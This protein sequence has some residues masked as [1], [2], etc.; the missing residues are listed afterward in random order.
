MSIQIILHQTDVLSM[1]LGL[2][3]RPVRSHVTGTPAGW[4]VQRQSLFQLSQVS[5]LLYTSCRDEQAE[6]PPSFWNQWKDG[7]EGALS[8]LVV[9]RDTFCLFVALLQLVCQRKCFVKFLAIYV[10][11]CNECGKGVQVG[12][13]DNE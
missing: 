1:R 5:W 3:D 9:H 6:H 12:K 11:L 7:K 13:E 10:Y 8:V 2:I 4:V